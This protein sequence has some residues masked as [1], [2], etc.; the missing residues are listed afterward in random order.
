MQGLGSPVILVA[1]GRGFTVT[2]AIAVLEQELLSMTVTV[3]VALIVGTVAI[4]DP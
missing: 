2:V 1:G 3:Y 4:L